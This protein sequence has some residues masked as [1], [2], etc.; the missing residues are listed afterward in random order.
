[1][2]DI[3]D[4]EVV[5]DDGSLL[6]VAL[7][8]DQ[9]TGSLILQPAAP[10]AEIE[11]AFT[12]YQRVCAHLL[13]DSD[14]QKIGNGRF[15]K[16]SGWRKL[17]TAFAV[18]LTLIEKRIDRDD[19]G[20]IR[21]AEFTVRATA[22][23]G[24]HVDGWGLCDRYERCCQPGCTKKSSGHVHC[25]RAQPKGTCRGWT[26]FS[27]AEH[28]IP[29]TAHTR[30][31]N[32]ASSDLFGMGEVSAEEVLEAERE[33]EAAMAA[34]ATEH[35]R[36][37]L[38][39]R[40]AALP[41]EMRLQLKATWPSDLPPIKWDDLTAYHVEQIGSLLTRFE[42]Q[43]AAEE[44]RRKGRAASVAIACDE[45]AGDLPKAE[46]RYAVIHHATGGRTNSA[47]DV[48]AAEVEQVRA[49]V[50]DV[51]ACRLRLVEL[52]GAVVVAQGGPP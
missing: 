26:H 5:Q 49:V 33:E 40:V 3:I 13:D 37:M 51:K 28:D 27:K 22:P 39:E 20:V 35:E 42:R 36:A 7:T 46:V 30:A 23:N 6:P 4:A 15:R 8:P 21:R 2:T 10:L 41:E 48:T 25:G 44:K 16:K 31:N 45:I 9:P 1:V 14:Y 11:R 32:R 12:A 18:N 43:A 17:S 47:K 34:P 50:F 29:A 52:D 19:D 38:L 24:R